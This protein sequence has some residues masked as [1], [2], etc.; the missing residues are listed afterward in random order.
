[1]PDFSTLLGWIE[2]HK[3]AVDLVKWALLLV[4]AWL[5]GAFRYLRSLTRKPKASLNGT[6]S[7][8]LVER[9]PQPEGQLD[10]IRASFLLEV[11]VIN[12]TNEKLVVKDFS[13]A[14]R[15]RSFWR[16]WLP[17]LSAVSLPERPRHEMGSG[18]KILKT[19]F[20]HFPDGID[21]LTLTGIV[22]AKD[23]ASG[24]LLFVS[25]TKG[26]WNPTIVEGRVRVLVRIFLTTGEIL[27]VE[28]LVKITSDKDQFERWVP[29]IINQ[30]SDET[31]WNVCTGP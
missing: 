1:M 2:D 11:G 27:K 18:T 23:F 6:T 7:R 3:T 30:I 25:F 4:V 31:A 13:L 8:C 17:E 20:S 28:R 9:F 16:P 12:R 22:E 5:A 24:F 21:R 15:R 19:W 26:A 10:A 14:V 29:G